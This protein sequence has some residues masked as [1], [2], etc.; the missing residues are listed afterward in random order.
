[1]AAALVAFTLCVG[2]AFAVARPSPPCTKR[3]LTDALRRSGG[4]GRINT[5]GCAGQFAY[6]GVRVMTGNGNEADEITALFRAVGTV[7]TR[8]SF[9]YCA[10]GSVPAR[11]RQPACYSN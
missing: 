1:M 10:D 11:I 4:R 7:W 2:S 8:A 3:A 5:F 9:K 6:A